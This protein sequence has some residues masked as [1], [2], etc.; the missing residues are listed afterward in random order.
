MIITIQSIQIGRLITEGDPQQNDVLQRQWTTG[1][2]KRPVAGPVQ[3]RRLGLVGDQVADRRNHGGVDK[4]ILCYAA[5]HYPLWA[6]E[7]PQLKMSP[8]AFAENLTL[9]G[10]DETTVCI[11][12]R[13]RVN[14]CVIEVS[15]PRQ[16]CWKIARRWGLK[17]LTKAVTQ[18]GRTGWYMRVIEEGSLQAG[19]SLERIAQPHPDWPVARANDVM[20]SRQSDRMAVF[21]LMNLPELSDQW[22]RD[23]G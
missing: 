1:F 19:Q 16:P 9:D 8:G 15:Q 5:S 11:G 3:L 14:D 23:V 17:T 4:A 21:E 2:Y 6:A 10:A 12:D 20:F 7:Y 13:Y 18:T 22:K